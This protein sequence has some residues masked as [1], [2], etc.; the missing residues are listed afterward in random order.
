[1]GVYHF[2]GL[3]RAVGAVT[4][5]IDYIEKALNAIENTQATEECKK[6]FQG[7]GGISHEEIDRGK[8]EA[9]VLFTS[10]EVINN[11]LPAF[12]F[13][14]HENPG[15]VRQEVVNIVRKVWKRIDPD[16]GR[17]IFWCEVDID[18][19][20]DCFQKIIQVAY[21]F[22]PYG[23]QGKEIWCNLTGGSNSIGFAL[24]S[25]AR[26]T[27]K[28]T[29]HYLISQSKEFQKEIKV[30]SQIK[31][32][33]PNKDGYFNIVPFLKTEIDTAGFYRIL[34]IM[35]NELK[36]DKV[37]TSELFNRLRSYDLFTSFTIKEFI[38]Q[39]MLKIHSLGYT[40][41]DI[42]N[43]LNQLTDSG[44]QF[45]IEELDALKNVITPPQSFSSYNNE[46]SSL[47]EEERLD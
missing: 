42:K 24:L 19:F 21:R 29:K 47:Y 10:K 33:K 7:T 25:M 28:S 40:R 9:I 26:L 13:S 30:P 16:V 22:S 20:Q 23:R 37:S 11:T 45:I 3:G 43:D 38:N 2:M 27:G 12:P 44:W 35:G 34:E 5:A 31:L 8:I 4:C 6:L 46:A 41:Y 17:K 36:G 14:G 1:M 32:I 39:Y 15:P 18:N